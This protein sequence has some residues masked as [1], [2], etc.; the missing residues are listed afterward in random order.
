MVVN[1]FV[2]PSN[3]SAW[4]ESQCQN[5]DGVYLNCGLTP[6]RWYYLNCVDFPNEGVQE[7][8]GSCMPLNY[9]S[10]TACRP[11]N[12]EYDGAPAGIVYHI[13]KPVSTTNST[14]Q[15]NKNILLYV[16]MALI[17]LSG[18]AIAVT[19]I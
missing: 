10:F 6:N 14:N 16:I 5:H 7:C 9:G 8:A 12:M 17:L 2:N 4:N 15:P 19:L 3:I 13:I 18:I 1:N 11:S